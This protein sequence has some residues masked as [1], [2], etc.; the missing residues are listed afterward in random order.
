MGFGLCNA[1]ATF[2][3]LMALIFSGLVLLECLIYLVDI[4]IFCPTCD[5]HLL[6]IEKVFISLQ[7]NNLKI[8]LHKCRFLLPNV[9]FLGPLVI[10]DCIQ[11]DPAK[12]SYIA[13]WPLPES[14]S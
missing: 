5:V 7:E 2:Q 10:G 13:K 11:T 4:I 3:R 12:T 8:K 9:S 6:R 1:P 14:I